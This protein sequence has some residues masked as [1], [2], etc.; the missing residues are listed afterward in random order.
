MGVVPYVP[1]KIIASGDESRIRA[2]APVVGN[3]QWREMA[4]LMNW[5]YGRGAQLVCGNPRMILT[6]DEGYGNPFGGIPPGV[7]AN[8]YEAY[9]WPRTQFTR[10]VWLVTLSIGDSGTSY[11]EF[12]DYT[13]A[14]V[15][16]TWNLSRND[17]RVE[18]I[19]TFAIVEP[20]TA[21]AGMTGL[22]IFNEDLSEEYVFVHGVC[23]F[24][25]PFSALSTVPNEQTLNSKQPIYEAS[26]NSESLDLVAQTADTLVT[27]ARRCALFSWY[28][29]T[30]VTITATTFAGASNVFVVPPAIVPRH[31]YSGVTTGTVNWAMYG[32]SYG[33]TCFARVTMSSGHTTTVTIT[34]TTLAA[35]IGAS[36]VRTEDLSRLGTDGGIRTGSRD[37]AIVEVSRITA[38]RY[39]VFG[40]YMG[41]G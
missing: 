40:F 13:G 12:R 5:L 7:M 21:A 32:V 3:G 30:A 15:L 34:S 16:G 11:G 14:T 23:C 35:T 6:G 10:R 22:K 18:P 24:E 36:T 28:T 8:A 1:P 31:L 41:E 20:W 39:E 2:A 25:M 26:G 33:G 9:V 38:T 19:A 17:T 37:Y 29:P 27:H 4:D